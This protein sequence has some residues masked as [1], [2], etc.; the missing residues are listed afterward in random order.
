M[1]YRWKC[2]AIPIAAPEG[3]RPQS[4]ATTIGSLSRLGLVERHA[5]P[6]DGR[7]QRVTPTVLAVAN[8]T[9]AVIGPTLGGL[10]IGVGGRR[11]TFALN[12]PLAA[13][14]LN[15]GALRLPKSSH[16]QPGGPG[17]PTGHGRIATRL[18]LPGIGLF[19][20]GAHAA[21][22]VPAGHRRLDVHR[23]T[24]RVCVGSSWAPSAGSSQVCC[25][26]GLRSS[27][28]ACTHLLPEHPKTT[29]CHGG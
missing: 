7:K 16:V 15:L 17:G 18:D 25:T 29:S 14:A 13:A 4:T 2:H 11:T 6:E 24:Q 5:D 27:T 9:I 1:R 28:D 21:A 22:E 10:L 20:G 19:A 8:Q 3:V 23:S 12:I 26:C